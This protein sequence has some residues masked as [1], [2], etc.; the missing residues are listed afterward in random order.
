MTI[1]LLQTAEYKAIIT[2]HITQSIGY[3][4]SKNQDFGLACEVKHID[5][6]PE[7]PK[8]IKESFNETV[9]FILSGYTLESA[10]LEE[11]YFSFEAGFGAENFDSVVTVPLLAIKQILVGDTPI[12]INFAQHTEEKKT[13]HT[14]DTTSTK[15]SMEAL[16]KNPENKKLLEKRK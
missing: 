9:L 14:P 4:F 5:F 6:T 8:E 1:N 16:L 12:V 13:P 7:L 15:S 3:L 10:R 2:D 11:G